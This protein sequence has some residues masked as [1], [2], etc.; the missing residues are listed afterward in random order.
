M[1][2]L[3]AAIDRLEQ[4]RLADEGALEKARSEALQHAE[5]L[6]SLIDGDKN[7]GLGKLLTP[8]AS[9]LR[10][11]SMAGGEVFEGEPDMSGGIS[12]EAM[13]AFFVGR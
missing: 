11:L 1:N 2:P 4:Q 8:I 13:S 12:G 5:V 7:D 10:D 3:I 9:F 6:E